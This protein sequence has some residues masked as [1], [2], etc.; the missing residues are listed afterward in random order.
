MA[1][2]RFVF[3]GIVTIVQFTGFIMLFVFAGWKI[4]VA[5]F[6]IDFARSFFTANS[7]INTFKKGESR[8]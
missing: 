8:P 6:L 1:N 5:V 3:L 7:F 2:K 4:C